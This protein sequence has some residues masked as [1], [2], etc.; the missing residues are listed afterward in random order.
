M[1][2][3]TVSFILRKLLNPRWAAL[4]LI[5]ALFV[6]A[7]SQT[8]DQSKKIFRLPDKLGANF[9]SLGK[10]QTLSAEQSSALPDG[11]VYK[12]FGLESLTS[13]RYTDGKSTITVEAFQM[14]FDSD[15]FGLFTYNRGLQLENR[16]EF[17]T[18]RHFVSISSE[19]IQSISLEPVIQSLKENL[20]SSNSDPSP[21][22]S[23]LPEAGK[24]AGSE[25]YLVGPVALAKTQEFSDLKEVV[26]FS[27]GT[28]AAIAK[29]SNGNGT[30]SLMIVE[31]HTPQLAT[32]GEA[33]F[34]NYFGKLSE[35]ERSQ[36][37]LKR[38]GNYLAITTAVQDFAGAEKIVSAIKYTPVVY[39]EARKITDIPEA[40]R[41][42]DPLAIQEASETA[43]MIVRTFYW[44]GVMLFGAIVLG[45]ISGSIF[46]Y[47]NRYRRRKLGLDNMFSD[48]GGAVRLN[49]EEYLLSPMDSAAG[50]IESDEKAG[51]FKK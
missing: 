1:P 3:L 6:T 49:L 10:A 12:E 18:G 30:F 13:G 26:N 25:K 28:E 11:A 8:S 36:R 37:L 19:S 41:P 22:P 35:Q 42:P 47:W 40:F 21:L 15:A 9:V 50:K 23:H 33:Q 39:W 38:I 16:H 24:V 17:F 20:N 44:I 43:N 48:S 7:F 31:Y 32:D 5:P 51:K 4:C 45:I 14:K 34:Q 27:G 46:F 2:K 29:Y